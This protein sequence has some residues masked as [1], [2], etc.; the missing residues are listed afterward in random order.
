MRIYWQS[1]ER[2]IIKQSGEFRTWHHLTVMQALKPGK[3]NTYATLRYKDIQRR[4][5]YLVS[6]YNIDTILMSCPPLLWCYVQ[7]ILFRH[8]LKICL[9][10]QDAYSGHIVRMCVC[11]TYYYLK[12]WKGY[13]YSANNPLQPQAHEWMLLHLCFVISA[14]QSESKHILFEHNM[15]LITGVEEVFSSN[16]MMYKLLLYNTTL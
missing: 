10:Q 8:C 15:P 11:V 5:W 9:L 6:Y 2:Q 16:T 4:R 12:C 1:G 7:I 13:T 3:D 14:W